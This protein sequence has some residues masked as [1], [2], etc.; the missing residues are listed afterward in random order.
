[1]TNLILNNKGGEDS[2]KPWEKSFMDAATHF[3]N[4]PADKKRP[5][6]TNHSAK[7]DSKYNMFLNPA[8]ES[9]LSFSLENNQT[10]L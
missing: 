8:V 1:M 4:K 7:E 10:G 6:L 2:H 9:F 5:L 3:T